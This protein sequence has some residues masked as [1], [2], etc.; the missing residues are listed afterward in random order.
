MTDS[1]SWSLNFSEAEHTVKAMIYFVEVLQLKSC[2]SAANVKHDACV[3]NGH[4]NIVPSVRQ[5]KV[6]MVLILRLFLTGQ[7]KL[8]C[9]LFQMATG[10]MCYA[11]SFSGQQTNL[12]DQIPIVLGKCGA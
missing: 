3:E 12:L 2:T 7:S 6:L 5:E 9:T 1:F 8:Q 11:L 4:S 10:I